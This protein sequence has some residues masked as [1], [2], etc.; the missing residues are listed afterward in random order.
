M[1]NRKIK[2]RWE[3]NDNKYIKYKT[4][5]ISRRAFGLRGWITANVIRACT[6]AASIIRQY[7]IIIIIIVISPR[8]LRAANAQNRLWGEIECNT[9][10]NV[11]RNEGKEPCARPFQVFEN[12]N[13]YILYCTLTLP[14]HRL[15]IYVRFYRTWARAITNTLL[16]VGR[17][18][19][20]PPPPPRHPPR[21][22]TRSHNTAINS[23]VPFFS[24]AYTP[25]LH[26]HAVT[27]III[28][29]RPRSSSDGRAH[30]KTH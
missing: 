25:R 8:R 16:L 21:V 6:L 28:C 14:S 17:N 30:A 7:I 23:F 22:A 26:T 27:T 3:K 4:H 20:S 5:L 19:L 1:I 24:S 10:L 18:A 2:Y 15:C 9:M 11:A 29:A 12:T 13:K